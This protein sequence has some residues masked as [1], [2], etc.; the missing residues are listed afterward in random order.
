MISHY[1]TSIKA[2]TD[3]VSLVSAVICVTSL[4]KYSQIMENL[5]VQTSS[6]LLTVRALV[7]G[8]S[9]GTTVTSSTSRV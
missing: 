2:Y 4:A 8:C 6:G 3:L 5:A 1:L 9:S 7:T